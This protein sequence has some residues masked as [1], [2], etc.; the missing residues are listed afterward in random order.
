M[1]FR[2]QILNPV[3]ALLFF[4]SLCAC[5]QASH[6]TVAEAPLRGNGTVPEWSKDAVIYEVNIRQFS[7]EGNLVAVEKQLPRLA[8]MGVDI[9]WLMPIHPI[10][11]E[12]R[13]G[14]MGSYYAVR[15]Y[16]AVNPEYGT[17]EDFKRFVQKAHEQGL[18]VILDWVANHSAWDNSM[19]KEHPEWYTQD[20]TGKIVSPVAD[21]S[22]VADFNYDN[23]HLRNYMTDCLKY[24]VSDFD[25]DGYRC[26]IA[27]M[28]PITFWDSVR[29]ELDA[30][31]PVFMLA[32]DANPAMHSNGFD[33]TYNWKLHHLLNGIA[34]GKDSL[35][36]LDHLWK[37][38]DST[39]APA[40]Y[41][42]VFTSN[43][44][45][46]SWNGTEFERMGDGAE[47]M[48]VLTFCVPGMPL[49][50]SGQEAPVQK[51]LDF[52]EKD[53]INWNGY[54]KGSFYSKLCALKSGQPAL[55]NGVYG[56][57]M[58]R[59]GSSDDTRI[60]A[61]SRGENEVIGLFNFSATPVEFT[62]TD[63]TPAGQFKEY[64]T[65]TSLSGASSTSFS[66]NPWGYQILVRE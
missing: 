51:R 40:D 17:P 45:E 33:M 12:N 6:Q 9:L 5:N 42:M 29:T 34:Q 28:V 24:W 65:G 23:G 44:D 13:K 22:D 39:F 46:N 36:E 18:Y 38:E 8:E 32:E 52:F 62:L 56:G 7:P 27:G 59:L 30:I 4:F 50:Y 25:I 10:G 57:S 15:D 2:N 66:L 43:H 16:K 35:Q 11:I 58:Q 19:T 20:S 53:P 37:V 54:A 63:G 21:W 14:T 55:W 3:L 60:Y 41:R 48:A 31:K 1:D 26:D 47:A 49:I 61:I 64:F